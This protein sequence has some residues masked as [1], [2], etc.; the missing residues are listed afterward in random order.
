M[1][2]QIIFCS[3]AGCFCLV[4]CNCSCH[5]IWFISIFSLFGKSG[6]YP[7][8]LW[9]SLFWQSVWSVFLCYDLSCYCFVLT[10]VTGLVNTKSKTNVFN[11]YFLLTTENNTHNIS[12]Q[13]THNNR[14]YKYYLG[15]THRSPFPKTR[16]NNI[17][18]KKLKKAFLLYIQRIHMAMMR[19]WQWY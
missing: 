14:N 4:Y 19:F 13:T 18:L 8:L 6:S 16:F 2:Y 15:I 1:H 9:Q 10:S 5:V 11:H 7:S 17:H 3:F 12:I